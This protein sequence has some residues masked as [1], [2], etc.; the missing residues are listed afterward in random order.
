MGNPSAKGFHP[1]VCQVCNDH[2]PRAGFIIQ[3]ESVGYNCFNCKTVFKYQELSG[4]LSK[5]CKSVL[6]DF[7]FSYQELDNFSNSLWFHN[8]GEKVEEVTTLES[9]SKINL[10]TPEISLPGKCL[11]LSKSDSLARPYIDYLESRHVDWQKLRCMY[12]LGEKFENRVIIPVYRNNRLIYWQARTILKTVKPRYK[13]AYV[14]REAVMW[15]YNNFFNENKYLFITEGIFNAAHVDGVAL[16]SSEISPA[17][18]EILSKVK[19][20]K[21]IIVD[22]D[23]NG[24]LLAKQ[25]L[26]LGWK[27]ALLPD[28]ANDVNMAVQK[29]GA[30]Y[31]VHYLMTHVMGSGMQTDMELNFY[32]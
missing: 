10:D 9:L 28:G 2:S 7:G 31:T 32:V 14:S 30:V 15:G 4:N 17:Q 6:H 16:L 24:I 5:S 27:I 22:R 8:K 19:R 21:V 26:S 12:S 23:E 20:D 18:K 25:G 3:P 1:V 11:L 29:F 13:M